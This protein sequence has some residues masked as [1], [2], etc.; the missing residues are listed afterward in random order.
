[1][2]LSRDEILRRVDEAMERGTSYSPTHAMDRRTATLEVLVEIL[3]DQA[4]L[5]ETLEHEL[6][7]LR[8][9]LGG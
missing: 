8:E 4:E 1:M 7:A 2:R 6:A 5:I 9:D 3:I